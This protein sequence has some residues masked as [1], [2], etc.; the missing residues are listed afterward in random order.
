MLLILLVGICTNLRY[1]HSLDI[2]SGSSP[3]NSPFYNKKD[4]PSTHM[5][6]FLSAR[7]TWK[8]VKDDRTRTYS[9]KFDLDHPPAQFP[10]RMLHTVTTRFMVGQPN[11]PLLARARY[12]LFRTFCVPT[13]QYQTSQNVYW[14]VLADPRLDPDVLAN[15]KILLEPMPNAYLILTSNTTW[16]ADGVGVPNVTSYGVDIYEIASEYTNSNLQ[17]VTGN[18]SRFQTTL[19][20][21]LGQHEHRQQEQPQEQ[22]QPILKLDTLL[23]ADDGLHNQGV[24]WIQQMAVDY[25]QQYQQQQQQLKPD[26]STLA[27]SWWTVCATDHIE[28]HN[29]DVFLLTPEDYAKGGIGS[30][31]TGLRQAPQFCAS[32]GFTRVGLMEEQPPH[33][34][35]VVFPQ[36][37]YTNHAGV[38]TFPYCG[39]NGTVAHCWKREFPNVPLVLKTRT[40]TSDSMDH[41]NPNKNDYRDLEWEEVDDHPLWINETEKT[42]KILEQDF[43]VDRLQAWHTSMYLFEHVLEIIK[44]RTMHHDGKSCWKIHTM[45][46]ACV[47]SSQ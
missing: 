23:D 35:Y 24:E 15:L 5:Y 26:K 20:M 31:V 44:T 12:L 4:D 32:A 14:I 1:L 43:A 33:K 27:N 6:D 40:I 38:M 41:L 36:T 37:A 10:Y 8:S 46:C 17:I 19:L 30:G 42:W 22:R 28:W 29:R 9:P 34:H 21:L 3:L 11:Q 45:Y 18:T 47:L 7:P 39:V 16:V 2:D 25:V 13:M